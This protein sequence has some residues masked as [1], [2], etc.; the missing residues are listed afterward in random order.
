[1]PRARL[2]PPRTEDPRERD[3]WRRV[4]DEEDSLKANKVIG[5][6]AGNIVTLTNDGD[7]QDSGKS[8]TDVQLKKRQAV[9]ITA[10]YEATILDEIIWVNDTAGDVRVT[11]PPSATIKG[12]TFIVEKISDTT[13]KS[14][15]A[16][17]GT[18]TI[19]GDPSF[20]LLLQYESVEP[21][22]TGAGYLI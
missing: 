20:D 2:R 9:T 6:T 18:E 14:I 10:D 19:N 8:F 22:S 16:A 12:Q 4:Q 3:A 17:T 5:G 13:N 7:I 15:V 21:T 1:M 11:L